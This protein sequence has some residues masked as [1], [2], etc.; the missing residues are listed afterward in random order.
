MIDESWNESLSILKKINAFS[1]DE[2]LTAFIEIVN[3]K[4]IDDAL[5]DIR[6]MDKKY[7]L[8]QHPYEI[9]YSEH[10]KRYRTYLPPKKDGEKRKP[11]T[12][13]SKENLENKI[14]AYYKQTEENPSV[15]DT[16][17]KIY[18]LFLDY[19]G[20]ETSLANAHK[21]N[22]VWETYYK[23]ES[24]VKCKF[25]EIT[26]IMLKSWFLDK[27]A[28]HNLTSRK[29]KE[30]KSLINMLYD[31]AIESNL[32]DRNI[33]RVIHN[34]SYKKYAIAQKKAPTEQ[35][36]INDEEENI[37]KV[38]LSQYEKTGNTAYLGVC[39]NFTLA[40][41]VG[42]VVALKTSDFS[43][44]LVHIQRTEIKHY[45]KLDNGEIVR[46]GYEV[47][48]HGKT[49]NADR[50]LFL[51]RNAKEFMSMIVRANEE[52][53]FH[54]EY[55][56]LDKDG[57][58]MHND[59]INNVLRRLNR[60]IKTTQKG[61]HSIRKTCISNMGESGALSNE[62][63]RTFAGHKDFSTTEKFYMHATTSFENRADAYERAI[64][65]K[66]GNVFKSVQ[67]L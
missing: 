35:V 18:P 1:D 11:I 52:R 10:D 29:Y 56:L 62:E 15:L 6:D 8:E 13:V 26:V 39:L 45:D 57:E 36:Y 44:I 22:W 65:S 34:I 50:E 21:L 55:L 3:I 61:N 30:M 53:N 20:K 41:R 14:V 49:P 40:L 2:A 33:S 32:T 27:I 25:S 16:F 60:M 58:R 17:E 47:V 12:A 5:N 9:Y 63:I 54:S 31:F 43:E 37:I 19:K 48:P 28:E 46:N 64:N 24:I 67:N 51:T 38:A 23:N 42:E 66:I 59:A 7:Y 4:G